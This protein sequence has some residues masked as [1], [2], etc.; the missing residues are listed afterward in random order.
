MTRGPSASSRR[1][2]G[3]RGEQLAER[4][5][6]GH[7]LRIL[8]RNVH[9]RHAEIDLV[10][11]DGDVL[12]IVEVRLRTGSNFGTARESVDARKR[13]RLGAAASELLA[14]RRLPRHRSLRFDVV[15]IDAS[16]EPP[17]IEH[18]RDAFALTR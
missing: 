8:A 10:A 1:A 18:L 12:C 7:G 4:F 11:L 6:R 13:R 17:R 9:L 5:L 2:L 3:R 16:V 15:A 14:T